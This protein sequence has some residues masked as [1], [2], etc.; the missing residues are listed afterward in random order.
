MLSTEVWRPALETEIL[1]AHG[2][3]DWTTIE[4]SHAP[5]KRERPIGRLQV[6][7]RARN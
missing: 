6:E 1:S 5:D 3:K 4:S 7:G 2:Y